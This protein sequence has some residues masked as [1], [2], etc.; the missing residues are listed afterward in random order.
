VL[1]T[2]SFLC[3]HFHMQGVPPW[4]KIREKQVKRNKI[5][6][7]NVCVLNV[8]TYP[9]ITFPKPKLQKYKNFSLFWSSVCLSQ[10]PLS[11]NEKTL[12]EGGVLT[13]WTGNWSFTVKNGPYRINV[14]I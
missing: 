10:M 2:V 9:K 13:E 12:T 7:V 3:F 6:R 11:T 8:D 14:C 4:K 1:Q 5:M